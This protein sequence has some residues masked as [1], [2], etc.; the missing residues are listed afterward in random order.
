M[1]WTCEGCESDTT[2]GAL[3][4]VNPDGSVTRT[5]GNVISGNKADGIGSSGFAFSDL[6]EGNFIGTDASGMIDAPNQGDGIYLEGANEA[7][8]GGDR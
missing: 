3:N 7:I 6:I 1:A 4:Q 8:V 5:A 2:I